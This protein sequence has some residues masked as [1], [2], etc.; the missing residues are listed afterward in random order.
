MDDGVDP[1]EGGGQ[2]LGSGDVARPELDPPLIGR[3]Q[4]AED[5]RPGGIGTDEGDDSM[6]GG[7]EG[8]HDVAADEAR[9]T[10]DEDGGHGASFP[11]WTT[12]RRLPRT[13]SA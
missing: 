5:P 13:R 9:G 2:R 8:G 1:A 10:R 4:A 3:R 7:E 6:T 11:L 12:R